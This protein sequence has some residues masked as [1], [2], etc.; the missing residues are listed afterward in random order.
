MRIKPGVWMVASA[1]GLGVGVVGTQVANAQKA[2]APAAADVQN[3][4]AE[5][6]SSTADAA[7]TA[8]DQGIWLEQGWTDVQRQY[9]HYESQGTSTIPIPYEWFMNLEQPPAHL[10]L[11]ELIKAG[12]HEGKLLGDPDYLP[13]TLGFIPGNPNPQI[14][15]SRLPVGFSKLNNFPSPLLGGKPVSALGLTCAACHTGQMEYNGHK[16][17]YDGGPAMSDLTGLTGILMRS[18][19]VTLIAPHHFNRFADRVMADTDQWKTRADLRDDY[20]KVMLGLVKSVLAEKR[21]LADAE[22]DKKLEAVMVKI[23]GMKGIP[24]PMVLG[25]MLDGMASTLETLKHGADSKAVTEGFTRLDALNRIGNTVFAIDTHTP[26]N[27]AEIDAPVSYPHIWTTSWF[28]WV[29]YDGSVMQPMVRNAGESLGVAA[30]VNMKPGEKQY[31]SSVPLDNL[32]WMEELLAGTHN[33]YEKKH[34]GGLQSPQWPEQYLGPINESKAA[35]G[36]ELYKQMCQQCHMPPIDSKEF[37]TEKVW[38]AKGTAGNPLM[39]MNI[40]P[41]QYIGTDSAQADILPNRT[42]DIASMKMEES[43]PSI[44]LVL[45]Y[46]LKSF[47]NKDTDST[48][49]EGAYLRYDSEGNYSDGCQKVEMKDLLTDGNTLFA[50]ALGATVQEVN[51]FWYQTHNVSPYVQNRMN[52]ERLNCLQAG[53]GYKARPLNGIWATAPFLHNGSV[54]TLFH[55]L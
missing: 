24:D 6:A 26:A 27:F 17:R 37:W 23:D 12:L 32:Y 18:M 28:D 47:A 10:S 48:R 40:I 52:G 55:L 13:E 35:E 36:A 43:N 51:D 2:P 11:K 45:D 50:A 30:L 19:V 3:A 38:A 46:A 15:P 22:T 39:A 8:V 42:V 16:I 9:Y 20:I 41:Q 44:Y 33:P 49:P 1:I 34:F 5:N 7:Q 21:A 25:K 31:A 14:N 53:A 29:Q 54:P 4:Y